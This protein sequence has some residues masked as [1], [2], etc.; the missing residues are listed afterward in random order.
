MVSGLLNRIG[1]VQSVLGVAIAHPLSSAA[2]K[3]ITIQSFDLIFDLLCPP[4]LTKPVLGQLLAHVVLTVLHPN[5]PKTQS[6][7]H[8]GR[9]HQRVKFPAQGPA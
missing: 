6:A 2:L 9:Q 4:Y 3:G 7:E 1:L 5:R 8:E